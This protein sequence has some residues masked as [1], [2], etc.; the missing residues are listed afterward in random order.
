MIIIAPT[1]TTNTDTKKIFL[2]GGITDCPD[3][4]APIARLLDDRTAFEI[5]NPRQENWNIDGGEKESIAQIRWE[6]YHLERSDV[7]LFWFPQETLCPITLLE[8]GKYLVSDKH[9]IIGTHPNYKRRLDV[10]EQTRLVRRD[11]KVWSN[12]D[13]MIHT[14]VRDHKMLGY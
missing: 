4:Q 7:I 5:F 12:L 3:W 14:F 9:L 13:D 10:I 11:A 6:A 8:L 2:A 1:V